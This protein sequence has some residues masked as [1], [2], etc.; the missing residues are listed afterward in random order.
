[1]AK[2]AYTITVC[3]AHWASNNKG[4]DVTSYVTKLVDNPGSNGELVFTPSNSFFGNQDPDP[5]NTK[6]CGVVVEM[7]VGGTT[8]QYA[9]ACQEGSTLQLLPDGFLALVKQPSCG[10]LPG[11]AQVFGGI[12]ACQFGG[13][14]VSAGVQAHMNCGGLG[15][16][17][18]PRAFA[19]DPFV[20]TPKYLFVGYGTDPNNQT[21][22]AGIDGQTLTF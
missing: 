14:D 13:L 10:I 5:G 20:G 17:V 8:T 1:M 21:F 4:I 22:K 15:I 7:T 3:S 12:Y 2:Q 6:Y 16:W 11:K 9:V 19:Y 18:D